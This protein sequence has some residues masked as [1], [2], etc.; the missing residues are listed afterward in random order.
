MES[1]RLIPVALIAVVVILLII[2]LIGDSGGIS[3]EAFAIIL[4]FCI[5]AFTALIV[6]QKDSKLDGR[7][8]AISGSSSPVPD[9]NSNSN[10]ERTD[11]INA[12]SEL[13]DP[14]DEGFDTPFS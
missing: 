10:D 11:R 2:R 14:L 9:E 5:G 4:L 7:S 13:P 1:R 6:T 8:S 12:K 3:Q